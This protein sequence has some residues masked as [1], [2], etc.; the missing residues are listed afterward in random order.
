MR[1]RKRETDHAMRSPRWATGNNRSAATNITKEKFTAETPTPL[2]APFS[3]H[4]RKWSLPSVPDKI[5]NKQYKNVINDSGV[6]KF[7]Q[8]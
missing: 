1:E 6:S 8:N 7:G 2:D 5:M 4:I 3:K